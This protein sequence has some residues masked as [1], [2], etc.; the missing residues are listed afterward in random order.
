[1]KPDDL[2]NS[3]NSIT[4]DSYMETRLF[5]E[6]KDAEK[7][8]RKN[9]KMFKAAVC[10]VLCCAVLAAGI[11]IGIPKKVISDSNNNVFTSDVDY[12][13]N[14]FVMSVY[15]A[16]KDK[17][18]AIPIDD[19]TVTLPEYKLN[20][21]ILHSDGHMS[22]DESGSLSLLIKGENINS[23]RIQCKNGEFFLFDWDMFE[24]LRSTN[25]FYDIIVPYTEEYAEAK[26][27]MDI[28]EII[29][30]HIENGDYDEYFKENKKKPIDSYKGADFVYDDTAGIDDN[31][32][33]V[34]LVSRETYSKFDPT[35]SLDPH[36]R[37]FVKD[38]TLYNVLDKTEYTVSPSLSPN[39][40][41]V[42]FENPDI[43][44][45]AL[46]HEE[47][48]VDVTFKDGTVQQSKYDFGLNSNG[49]LVIDRIAED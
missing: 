4:P 47:I 37:N 46:P 16:E 10:T 29:Y 12:S 2:K 39:W 21:A 36:N 9:R 24:Y 7:P 1:M 6:I 35:T 14:Y 32:V 27:H 3:L 17:K 18:T 34:G 23:V 45:D 11:G 31:I 40:Y 49:E 41:E 25:Q 20:K 8:K 22:Y 5:A 19:H 26:T 33:G 38:H 48:T 13:G 15:A 43:A 44:F 30:K 28:E 42:L